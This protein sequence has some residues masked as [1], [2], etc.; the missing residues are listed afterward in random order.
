MLS[1]T[2]IQQVF[3]TFIV[4]DNEEFSAIVRYGWDKTLGINFSFGTIFNQNL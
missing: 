2:S 3:L 1:S 4:I